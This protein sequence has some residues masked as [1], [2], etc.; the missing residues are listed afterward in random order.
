MLSALPWQSGSFEK[1]RSFDQ[2]FDPSFLENN[3]S[4]LPEGSLVFQASETGGDLIFLLSGTVRI[5]NRLDTEGQPILHHALASERDFQIRPCLISSEHR[6]LE[7]IAETDVA[8][9]SLPNAILEEM[10]TASSEFRRF[11]FT[12]CSDQISDLVRALGFGAGDRLSRM[13]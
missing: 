5:Q 10:M 3:V 2:V 12:T 13:N 4:K 8:L 6:H 9:L 11:I 1:I 7:V